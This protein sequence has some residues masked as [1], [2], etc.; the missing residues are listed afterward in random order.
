VN[1]GAPELLVLLG[2]GL[3]PFA[4]TVWALIDSQTRP[5]AAWLQTGQSKQVW[6]VLLIVGL[7]F[8][9]VG[10]VASIVYL[11]TVRP[12]LQAATPVGL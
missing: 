5:D 10:L 7:F 1:L 12:K 2:G 4:L 3:I 9:L 6:L 11:A 8:C